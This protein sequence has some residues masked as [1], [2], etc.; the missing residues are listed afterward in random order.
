MMRFVH[1]TLALVTCSGIVATLSAWNHQRPLLA[2]HG[3]L[4][5][6][7]G[8]LDVESPD[9]LYFARLATDQPLHFAWRTRIPE[10]LDVRFICQT[11][12]GSSS[13]SNSSNK[14]ETILRWRARFTDTGMQSYFKSGSGS[15]TSSTGN[16]KLVRF[17]EA[18]ADRLEV[19]DACAED[20]CSLA[21]EAVL[22]LLTVRVPEDMKQEV[23]DTL[24]ENSPLL[25]QPVVVIRV[26]TPQAYA[27][28]AFQNA[29]Q[30]GG[31]R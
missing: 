2:E 13:S 16:E 12:F 11:L 26:G 20:P 24:G 15:S 8:R 5:D 27:D 18:N 9:R 21:P 1:I 14:T 25:D 19:T 10:D 22:T 23:I 7:V 28:E 29:K 30:G 17:L 3:E 6:Q 4:V 31:N